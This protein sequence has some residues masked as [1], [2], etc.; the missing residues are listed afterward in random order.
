MKKYRYDNECVNAE[1]EVEIDDENTY[2][3]IDDG[4]VY[5]VPSYRYIKVIV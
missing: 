3:T 5:I 2:A 1:I 4:I